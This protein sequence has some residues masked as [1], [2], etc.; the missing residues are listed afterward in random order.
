MIKRKPMTKRQFAEALK[1]RNLS[2]GDAAAALGKTTR[3]IYRYLCGVTPIPKSVE[4]ALT[5]IEPK[6]P[7]S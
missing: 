6:E 5:T 1:H 3:Q 4:M 2:P 7:T